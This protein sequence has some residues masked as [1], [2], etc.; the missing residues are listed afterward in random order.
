MWYLSF[1]WITLCLTAFSDKGIARE[2]G[3]E[4]R[5][6]VGRL[7]LNPEEHT[8]SSLAFGPRGEMLITGHTGNAIRLWNTESG[9]VLKQLTSPPIILSL[10]TSPNGQLIVSV[11]SDRSV[12]IWDWQTGKCIN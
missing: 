1:V 5:R 3:V 6:L 10:A 7:G 9:K 11:A 12:C 4:D 8:I 2:P